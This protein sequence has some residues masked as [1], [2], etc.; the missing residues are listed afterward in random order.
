MKALR[1]I[2][3]LILVMAFL[4]VIV[5]KALHEIFEHHEEI[6]TCAYK[7]QTHFHKFKIQHQDVICSFNFSSGFL[8][9]SNGFLA[10][11]LSY[12][13]SSVK[14]KYLW[15]VK[16]YYLQNSFLRGPPLIK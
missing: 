1:N 7:D 13:A 3:S 10:R 11:F 16:N 4:N 2:V 6:H 12:F 8:T 9:D 14:V 15:L 5:G